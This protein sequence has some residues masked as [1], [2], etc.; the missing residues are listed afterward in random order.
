MISR[1]IS[2]VGSNGGGQ[3]EEL[4]LVQAGREAKPVSLGP[5][6]AV[7]RAS[8]CRKLRTVSVCA[9]GSLQIRNV[10]VCS[11]IVA[12]WVVVSLT[13]GLFVCSV[14]MLVRVAY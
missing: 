4:Q 1:R 11:N 6:A 10:S 2:N 14:L 12:Q 5:S 9:W 13:K 8:H 3:G 7:A